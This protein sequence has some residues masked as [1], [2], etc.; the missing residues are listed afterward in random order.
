[1]TSPYERMRSLRDE[2][3]AFAVATVVRTQGSTPQVVGAKLLVT[4]DE[5][6]R[7]FGTLTDK[8]AHLAWRHQ[9]VPP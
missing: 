8:F 9:K 5:T 6:T 3:T 7:P 4:A 1:M 2:G